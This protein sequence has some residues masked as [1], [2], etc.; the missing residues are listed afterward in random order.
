MRLAVS[1][2]WPDN[3][4][5]DAR[6]RFR[7]GGRPPECSQRSPRPD[8][9][10]P[11]RWRM[12]ALSRTHTKR[13]LAPSLF[14]S[15]TC[16]GSGKRMKAYCSPFVHRKTEVIPTHIWNAIHP[17]YSCLRT[18]RFRYCLAPSGAGLSVSQ[19]LRVE[20]VLARR[21]IL[22]NFHLLSVTQ[23]LHE[24][25]NSRDRQGTYTDVIRYLL[26]TSAITSRRDSSEPFD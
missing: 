13:S 19:T 18:R 6:L 20:V 26:T 1:L 7:N 4:A 25:F 3:A 5:L 17:I 23:F 2:D 11:R 10:P 22:A 9:A 16:V 12:L 21:P 8:A 24:Y 14:C 15:V